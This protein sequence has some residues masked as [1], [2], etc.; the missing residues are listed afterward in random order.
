MSV[1]ELYPKKQ[2]TMYETVRNTIFGKTNTKE[3]DEIEYLERQIEKLD[4]SRPI[5]HRLK[6]AKVQ[7]EMK[8]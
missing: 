1:D 5:N 8:D 6:Q 2:S 3:E 7:I 4:R